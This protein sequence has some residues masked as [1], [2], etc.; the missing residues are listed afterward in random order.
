MTRDILEAAAREGV[1]FVIKMADGEKYRVSSRERIIIGNARVVVM[2]DNDIPH[3]LPLL[4]MTAVSYLP[5]E[6][7]SAAP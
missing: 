5:R 1:P 4:T 6:G 7:E 2:D 3:V